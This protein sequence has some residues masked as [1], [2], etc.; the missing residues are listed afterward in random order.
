MTPTHLDLP[1]TG[2]LRFPPVLALIPISRSAGR[3]A[4]KSPK[5]IKFGNTT[6]WRAEAMRALINTRH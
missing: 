4:G 3:R 5:D 2:L 1:T 6:V